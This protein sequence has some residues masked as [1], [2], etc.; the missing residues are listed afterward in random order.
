MNPWIVID[1]IN[2]TKRPSSN[3]QR[4]DR[5]TQARVHIL[6]MCVHVQIL[7]TTLISVLLKYK[8]Y[9]CFILKGKKWFKLGIKKKMTITEFHYFIFT[10]KCNYKLFRGCL[11]EKETT[12]TVFSCFHT[13]VSCSHSEYWVVF[14]SWNSSRFG[15]WC[16]M[17]WTVLNCLNWPSPMFLQLI[18]PFCFSLT[19]VFRAPLRFHSWHIRKQ[20]FIFKM[21]SVVNFSMTE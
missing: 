15:I 11:H 6:Q 9:I 3:P 18:R 16:W 21:T 5:Q 2:T 1:C 7:Y 17:N 20:T 13:E 4:T 8:Y 14:H 10:N 19:I 12:K